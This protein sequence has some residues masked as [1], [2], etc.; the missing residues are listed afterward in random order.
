MKAHLVRVAE[1]ELHE[2][3]PVEVA[4]AR[5]FRERPGS[6]PV[7]GARDPHIDLRQ[8]RDG[9]AGLVE[10]AAGGGGVFRRSALNAAT[11][12]RCGSACST[13]CRSSK[14]R[15]KRG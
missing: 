11:V 1:I 14:A 5:R 8:E 4:L 10:E 13:A 12:I 6:V 7:P 2:L 3:D 9:G 15:R